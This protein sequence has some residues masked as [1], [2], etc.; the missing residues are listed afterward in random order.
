MNINKHTMEKVSNLFKVISDPTR[1]KILYLLNDKR[2]TVSQ[3]YQGLNMTQ[4]AISH[5][6]KILRE[7]NLVKSERE[8]KYIYYMLSDNHVYLIFNQAIEHVSE[9]DNYA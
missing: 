9:E 6:L 4:T 1:I 2:L 5:Q 8:G 3:I 7:T